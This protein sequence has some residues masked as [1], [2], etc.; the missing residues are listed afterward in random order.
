MFFGFQNALWNAL[1]EFTYSEMRFWVMSLKWDR[2]T[3]TQTHR[4]IDTQTHRYTDTQTHK[5]TDTQ[6]HR[7][8]D[9]QIQFKMQ[10]TSY[11]DELS[12]FK[13]LFDTF[14]VLFDTFKV[15][16]DT[17]KVLFDTFKVKCSLRHI[18]M[19]CVTSK[20]TLNVSWAIERHD[21]F[22]CVPWLLHM[23]DV[24]RSYVTCD[25]IMYVKKWFLNVSWATQRHDSFVC[26]T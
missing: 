6:T 10:F 25:S 5:H 7:H 12:H 14:K 17:F 2:H 16:F 1:H 11:M 26:V 24:T 22:M 9:T 18:W 15:L 20:C 21:S 13:V 23:C 3:D 4:H 8:T 19:N